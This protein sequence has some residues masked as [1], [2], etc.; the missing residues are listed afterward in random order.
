[1]YD[2]DTLVWDVE[3]LLAHYGDQIDREVIRDHIVSLEAETDQDGHPTGGP[4]HEF[5]NS[6]WINII[7][8]VSQN[9]ACIGSI[10]DRNTVLDAMVRVDTEWL[11]GREA[12]PVPSAGNSPSEAPLFWA[13]KRRRY[14]EG[15]SATELAVECRRVLN[16]CNNL[17][18][19]LA[20]L[21]ASVSAEAS[22]RG[23][24]MARARHSHKDIMLYAGKALREQ[25]FT[26]KSVG[27][28][29]QQHPYEHPDGPVVRMMDG[30]IIVEGPIGDTIG[31][32]VTLAHFGRTYMP[33]SRARRPQKSF[34]SATALRDQTP[35]APA[36][37]KF[38]H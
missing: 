38:E 17:Q 35:S 36:L 8:H 28:H 27:K 3:W 10:A 9:P 2:R 1:M 29:L 12:P 33:T 23:R 31:E 6:I 4:L 24:E 13:I 22:A 37:G 19:W 15:M 5:V 34:P 25:G 16:R 7:E 26:P 32:A 30:K 21:R 20:Q 18:D 11:T 14:L